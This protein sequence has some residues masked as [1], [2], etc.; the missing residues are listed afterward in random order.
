M[1]FS[2]L[3]P[4]EALQLKKKRLK[5]EAEALSSALENKFDFLQK[6]F[7]PIIACSVLDS[8]VSKMPSVV[9]NFIFRQENSNG[10]KI[11]MSPILSGIASGVVDIIPLFMKGKKGLIISFLLQ[12]VR[13]LL[14][15]RKETG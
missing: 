12:Q 2:R 6:N 15:L 7:V 4:T 14:L 10:K 13:N 1:S 5:A 9:Q 8:A 3:T 11:R